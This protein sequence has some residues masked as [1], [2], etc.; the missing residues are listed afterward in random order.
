MQAIWFLTARVRYGAAGYNA[1]YRLGNLSGKRGATFSAD[2]VHSNISRD[3]RI[4]IA[5]RVLLCGEGSSWLCK[6]MGG[7]GLRG[8]TTNGRTG[9]G[10]G[11]GT[12]SG[13]TTVSNAGGVNDVSITQICSGEIHCIAR[14]STGNVWTTGANAAGQLGLGDT[15][16]PKWHFIKVTSNVNRASGVTITKIGA[17]TA[18]S[19][20]LDT[21]GRLWGCGANNVGE[22]GTPPYTS[23]V[24]TFIRV[25]A[26]PI[27]DKSI[28]DFALSSY[29]SIIARTS[30]NEYYVT[31]W[32]GLWATRNRRHIS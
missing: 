22:L 21:A 20:A 17:A 27:A 14:D 13:W 8:R 28:T 31:G 24:T 15:S 12:T 6:T 2:H 32:G 11:A 30:D 26:G 5:L 29:A 10:T 16:Q 1:D 3:A 9:Q 23:P 4:N 18:R 7:F 25:D 19:C